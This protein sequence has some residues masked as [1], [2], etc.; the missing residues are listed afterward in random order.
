[1]KRSWVRIPPLRLLGQVLKF[2]FGKMAA[3]GE[4]YFAGT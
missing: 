1:M 3:D 4:R 2:A